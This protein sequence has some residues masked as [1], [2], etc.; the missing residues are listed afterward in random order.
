MTL[1][2]RLTRAGLTFIL[3]GSVAA[4]LPQQSGAAMADDPCNLGT[5]TLSIEQSGTNNGGTG[6]NGTLT[7]SIPATDNYKVFLNGVLDTS[8]SIAVTNGSTNTTVTGSGTNTVQVKTTTTPASSGTIGLKATDSNL[9]NLV[10]TA[11]VTIR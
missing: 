10:A 5:N 11:T 7:Q 3:L 1:S 2:Q 9:T 6:T 8:G 4:A